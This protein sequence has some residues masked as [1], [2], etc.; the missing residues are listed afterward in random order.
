MHRAAVVD[1]RCRD[2]GGVHA[3]GAAATADP[4]GTKALRA[5]TPTSPPTAVGRPAGAG[6][7]VGDG[8]GPRQRRRRVRRRDTITLLFDS[9]TD[10]GGQAQ[11]LDPDGGGRDARVLHGRRRHRPRR[12]GDG[13]WSDATT[14]TLTIVSSADNRPT[15]PTS[16]SPPPPAS[17]PASSSRAGGRLPDPRRRRAVPAVGVQHDGRRRLWQPPPAADPNGGGERR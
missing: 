5:T 9:A 14:L 2:A 6:A 3:A 13:V 1:G 4:S 8:G 15:S 17:R 12:G 16:A 11:R 7:G 10:L